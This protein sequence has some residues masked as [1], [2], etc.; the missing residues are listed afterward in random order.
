MSRTSDV[1]ATLARLSIPLRNV[2]DPADFARRIAGAAGASALR[3]G[4]DQTSCIARAQLV[5]LLLSWAGL[6]PRV[7][8]GVQENLGRG[9]EAH[10]WVTLDGEA[11]G[12]KLDKLATYVEIGD[13]LLPR[14]EST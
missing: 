4:L 6:E 12:E 9:G 14:P 2:Q 3:L 5:F 13:P 8:T 10:A 1:V 11:V 7:R